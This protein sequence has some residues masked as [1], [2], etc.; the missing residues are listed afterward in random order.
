MCKSIL[1][2]ISTF[3]LIFF[4]TDQFQSKQKVANLRSM[5]FIHWNCLTRTVYCALCNTQEL[6]YFSD[7][8]RK[9]KIDCHLIFFPFFCAINYENICL[10]VSCHVTHGYIYQIAENQSNWTG[11]IHTDFLPIFSDLNHWNIQILQFSH[12]NLKMRVRLTPNNVTCR[13]RGCNQVMWPGD[14]MMS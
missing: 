7:R 12:L 10:I 8:L 9:F 14:M 4:Q 2:L 11:H 1:K 3:I 5:L 13:H 6:S